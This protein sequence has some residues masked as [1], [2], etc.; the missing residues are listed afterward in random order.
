MSMLKTDWV[1][2]IGRLS[3]AAIFI[4]MGFAKIGGY[5]GMVQFATSANVPFPEV[6]I[7]LAIIIELGGGLMIAL[8][9][10]TR[11]AAKALAV[12]VLATM[13]FFHMNLAD[14]GQMTMFLKNLAIFG[15]LLMLLAHGAGAYSIDAK[16]K[17]PTV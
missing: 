9:L 10:K 7:V 17:K 6:A 13:Y 14:Q 2:L 5:D 3:L 11:W 12:F 8:G 15:G 4:I 16:M 1:A